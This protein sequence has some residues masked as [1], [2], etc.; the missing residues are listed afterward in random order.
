MCPLLLSSSYVYAVIMYQNSTTYIL[1]LS[2]HNTGTLKTARIF[3][4]TNFTT[5]Q[6]NKAYGLCM[7]LNTC[8][9]LSSTGRGRA[10]KTIEPCTC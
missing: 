4:P 5:V 2:G 1:Y 9:W 6:K 10:G 3:S 8:T 7:S